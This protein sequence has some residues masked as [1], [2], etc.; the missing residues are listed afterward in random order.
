M[1]QLVP[2]LGGTAWPEYTLVDEIEKPFCSANCDGNSSELSV[3]QGK[4][5]PDGMISL[6]DEFEVFSCISFVN[7]VW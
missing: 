2:V 4:N 1:C 3:V 7:N 6:M 5:K